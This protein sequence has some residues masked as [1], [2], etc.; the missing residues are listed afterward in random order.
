VPSIQAPF[1]P[2]AGQDYPGDPL[3]ENPFTNGDDPGHWILAPY[4]EHIK[5]FLRLAREYPD[6]SLEWRADIAKWIL[7]PLPRAIIGDGT[8]CPHRPEPIFKLKRAVPKLPRFSFY[9]LPGRA[10][11]RLSRSGLTLAGIAG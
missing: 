6:L 4:F 3:F 7:W 8:D 5:H 9:K 10:W 1:P 11:M 2:P